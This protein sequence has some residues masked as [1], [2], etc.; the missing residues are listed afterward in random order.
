MQ[1]V[2]FLR[3][4]S[5]LNRLGGLVATDELNW[6]MLYLKSGLYVEHEPSEVFAVRES[7]SST[8]RGSRHP[9]H[10]VSG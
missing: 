7:G 10:E 6:W 9:R 8:I 5:R 1:L 4:R 3:R 2:H